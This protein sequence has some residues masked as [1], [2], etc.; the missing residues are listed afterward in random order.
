MALRIENN[1]SR[2]DW[3][4]L[5]P[6][7][8]LNYR[9]TPHSSTGYTPSDLFLAFAVK[10]FAARPPLDIERHNR[11]L[12]TLEEGEGA[13]KREHYFNKNAEDRSFCPGQNVL[14]KKTYKKKLELPG[15]LAKV[16]RQLNQSVVQ[17]D[18]GGRKDVVNVERLS[19]VEE[20]LKDFGPNVGEPMEP[21]DPNS[22]KTRLRPRPTKSEHQV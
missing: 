9:N 12:R 15:Q 10:T 21:T 6:T 8:L 11:A 20:G 7:A 17:V 19:P 5:L 18:I 4:Q 3:P 13:R 1:K 16:Q 14:V 2:T 22:W